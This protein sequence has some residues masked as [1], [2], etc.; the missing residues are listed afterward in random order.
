VTSKLTAS[1]VVVQKGWGGKLQFSD[2]QL[3][4]SDRRDMGA[5]KF[6]FSPKISQNGE[7]AVPNLVFLDENCPRSRKFF[8]RLKFMGGAVPLPRAPHPPSPCRG[9]TAGSNITRLTV[10]SEYV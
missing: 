1:G 4:I 8:D 3:P 10:D 9:A 7:F 6:E 2:R 5:Q